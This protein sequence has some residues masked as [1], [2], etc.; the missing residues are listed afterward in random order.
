MSVASVSSIAERTVMASNEPLWRLSVEQYHRMLQVG[1]LTEEDPIE[2]LEGLLVPKM[3]K[4]PRHCGATRL[5]RRALERL[6][7]DGWCVD[8]QDPIT[9]EDSEPEP[10]VSVTLTDRGQS[11]DR[12]PSAAEVGLV[13]EV[14][15]ASLSADRNRKKRVYARAGVPVYW[16]VNLVSS[17][18]EVYSQPSGQAESPTYDH[19]QDYVVGQ[20]VP[21]VLDAHEIG[22]LA[23]ADLLPS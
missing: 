23:V 11:P 18:V 22:R 13:V 6:V 19:R 2:L 7:P 17:R 15:D 12:H 5:V 8:V 21:V 14:S 9:L 3:I 16:I 4:S 10:D 1:I 20:E